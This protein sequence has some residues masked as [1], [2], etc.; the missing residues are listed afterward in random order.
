MHEGG[1]L[2]PDGQLVGNVSSFRN[3][4]MPYD[5]SYLVEGVLKGHSWNLEE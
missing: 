3:S 1:Q 4:V 5:T 2:P